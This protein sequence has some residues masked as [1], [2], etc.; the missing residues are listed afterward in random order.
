MLDMRE[1]TVLE[2]GLQPYGID[3]IEEMNILHN[4]MNIMNYE[5]TIADML[6][7]V[8][9]V[10]TTAEEKAK[11]RLPDYIL[12]DFERALTNH[13]ITIVKSHLVAD[14]SKLH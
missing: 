2:L 11:R 5:I 6:E 12:N 9:Q 4:A 7:L 8:C 3:L 13:A 14:A 10:I 1:Q